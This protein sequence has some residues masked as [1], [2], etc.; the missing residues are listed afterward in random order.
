MKTILALLI[1]TIS[2]HC[3][4][5]KK[6]PQISSKSTSVKVQKSSFETYLNNEDF[7]IKTFDVNKDGI[8]DKVVSNKPYQGENLFVF[9]G[10]KQGKYT[11]SLETRNFSEDG[12]NI[13]ND[14]TPLPDK[15]GFTIKHTSLIVD[16]MKR[17]IILSYKIKHGFFKTSSIK[18]CQ[19]FHRMQ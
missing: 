2:I 12:G 13:I 17:N 1:L 7:F 19:M 5:Q 8:T 6:T 10:D 4:S 9:L 14:I 3:H 11:L 15:K 16:T 18:Q